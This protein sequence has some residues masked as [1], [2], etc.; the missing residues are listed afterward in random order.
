[1]HLLMRELSAY[2]ANN[3]LLGVFRT[4]EEAERGRSKYLKSVVHGASDPWAKQSYH[5][6]SDEDVVILS[7]VSHLELADPADRVFVV[8]SHAEGFGQIIRSFEAIAGSNTAARKHAAALEAK[9]DGKFPYHC[10]IDEIVVGELSQDPRGHHRDGPLVA[11][12]KDANLPAAP[13]RASGELPRSTSFRG[14]LRAPAGLA[15]AAAALAESL[16]IASDHIQRHRSEHDGREGLSIATPAF[17]FQALPSANPSTW[18]IEGCITGF[19]PEPFTTI[20]IVMSALR[21][22]GAAINF[23]LQ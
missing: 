16:H 23:S 19:D 15:T 21:G 4:L 17:T 5:H 10:E 20:S 3:L 11:D 14:T 2:T 12:L 13:S 6:V 9:D 1:M 8:S 22:V 18:L 7:S